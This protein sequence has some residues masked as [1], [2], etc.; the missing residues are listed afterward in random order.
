MITLLLLKYLVL[1][2]TFTNNTLILS[3][4]ARRP[5]GKIL[6]RFKEVG[7]W[8][9]DHWKEIVLVI[10]IVVAVVCICVPGLHG[11]DTGMVTVYLFVG[12][13]PYSQYS[14]VEPTLDMKMDGLMS[15]CTNS[16]RVFLQGLYAII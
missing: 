4:T 10:E 13:L 12:T 7:Q 5:T 8:C 1:R 16:C 15:I 11:I 2:R 3:L 9:K 6:Q 14:Y